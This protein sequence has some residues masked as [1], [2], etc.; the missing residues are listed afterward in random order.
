M[1][2][3]KKP[4]Q[5]QTAKVKPTKV[6]LEMT[7]EE[8]YNGTLK[9]YKHSRTRLCNDCAGKGGEGVTKCKDCKGQ[10]QVVQMLQMG[11]GMYQQIQKHCD[12]CKG[13]G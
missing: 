11:P 7:L 10:G 6:G 4:S 8:S 5:K 9:K 12:K 3:G 2:G 1:R 13:Q